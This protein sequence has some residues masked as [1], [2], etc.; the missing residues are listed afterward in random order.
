VT[1][2]LWAILQD[3]ELLAGAASVDITPAVET[4][5]DAD[6]DGRRSRDET[7]KDLNGNQKWDPVWMAG[8]SPNKPALGVRDPLW[9][10]ALSLRTGKER[11]VLVSLDLIGLLHFHAKRL[12]ESIAAAAETRPE[13]VVVACTHNHSGPDTL[14]LWGPLPFLTGLNPDYLKL[15]CD[16]AVEASKKAVEAER[17]ASLSIAS[18]SGEGFFKDSRDPKILNETI[19]GLLLR[20]RSGKVVAAVAVAACHPE[21]VG[22]KNRRIT[23]DFPHALRLALEKEYPG[24]VGIYFSSDLGTLQSPKLADHSFETVDRMGETLASRLVAS[25]KAA[26]PE[27]AAALA[28]RS[29]PFEFELRNP[30]FRAGLKGGLFG[31]PKEGF[32]EEGGRIL[33]ASSLTAIRLGRLTLATLPG[34]VAPELGREIRALLPGDRKVLI[35][36]G[37]DEVGYIF[38]K[39][40]WTPG[41]YEESMSL[42][43]ETGPELMRAMRRLASGF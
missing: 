37:N 29:L 17:P 15:L 7:F 34:E 32:R 5:E 31:D 33:I 42:G 1:A 43:P 3:P 35:G 18:A 11:V 38:R 16:R 6:G 10:R 19:D 13:N 25:F 26:E 41:Q 40:D 23:S 8:F 39:E 2:V 27:P 22:R 14:G 20:D 30:L 24:S 4:F 28:S 12:R 21:G 36:L 9:A